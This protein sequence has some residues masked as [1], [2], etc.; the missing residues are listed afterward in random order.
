MNMSNKLKLA[1]LAAVSAVIGAISSPVLA[2]KWP[3]GR[4]AYGMVTRDGLNADARIP[5]PDLNSRSSM[6]AAAPATT[7]TKKFTKHPDWR[8]K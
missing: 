2:A 1:F 5:H 3:D 4:N 6:A 8:R 7:R